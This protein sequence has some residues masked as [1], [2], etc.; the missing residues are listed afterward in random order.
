MFSKGEWNV[1]VKKADRRVQRTRKI[2]LDA[3]IELMAEKGFEA[4]TV[5]EIIDHANVGRSTFYSHFIDKEQLLIGAIDRLRIFLE[6]RIDPHA[7]PKEKSEFRFGFSLAMLQHVQSH[8]GLYRMTAGKPK[9]MA[10]LQHMRN[11]LIHLAENEIMEFWATFGS[12]KIP[13][14]VATE[15]VV[16]TFLTV[17]SWWMDGQSNGTAEQCDQLFHQ[18]ILSGISTH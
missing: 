11:M 13:Y 5:Q 17:L 4:L 14:K 18:L 15:F 12:P 7:P 2:L 16:T 1:E 10:V 8:T 6:E 9:E 3:L